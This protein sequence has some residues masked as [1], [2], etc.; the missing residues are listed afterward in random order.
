[1]YVNQQIEPRR[2]QAQ[3]RAAT[4]RTLLDAARAVFRD[5]GYAGTTTEEVVRRAAVTRGALYHHFDDKRDLFR[6]VIEEIEI[7]IDQHVQSAAEG[8]T[9]PVR[10]FIAGTDA[11]LD[12]CLEPDVKQIFLLDGPAV[13]GWQEWHAI[14]VKHAVVQI[15]L[16]L[17]EL[18]SAGCLDPQPVRPLA[19]LL[20]GALIEAALV[21]AAADQPE[22]ERAALGASLLRLLGLD[23]AFPTPPHRATAEP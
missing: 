14:D 7:E 19:I 13:L 21:I 15:E 17:Q 2:S 16:G 9:D 1:M 23:A 5:Q 4:R 3:R 20:H 10:A 18:I 6:A 12:R 22:A 11:F 8:A